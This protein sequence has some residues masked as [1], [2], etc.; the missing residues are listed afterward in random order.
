M[1]PVVGSAANAVPFSL[2]TKTAPWVGEYTGT[3][4]WHGMHVSAEGGQHRHYLLLIITTTSQ[5]AVLA[6]NF[7]DPNT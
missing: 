6:R 4:P 1:V 7:S 2:A 3:P 5:L